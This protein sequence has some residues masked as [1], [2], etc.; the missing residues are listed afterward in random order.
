MLTVNIQEILYC[1]WPKRLSSTSL[2]FGN[3]S[4]NLQN[5]LSHYRCVPSAQLR[6]LAH[7]SMC[8]TWNNRILILTLHQFHFTVAAKT[9][10]AFL[11]KDL[12]A[13]ESA[14]KPQLFNVSAW[15]PLHYLPHFF[16]T[17]SLHSTAV[18]VSFCIASSLGQRLPIYDFPVRLSGHFHK[19]NMK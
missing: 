13:V 5:P 16:S 10:A 15:A 4:Q 6:G 17:L 8:H 14:R 2:R 3:V 7:W 9:L 1:Q 12:C 19:T 11:Q 18:S